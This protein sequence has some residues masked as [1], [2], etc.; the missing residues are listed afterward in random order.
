MSPIL[1][2]LTSRSDSDFER[3]NISFKENTPDGVDMNFNGF[4]TA[5]EKTKFYLV[6]SNAVAKPLKFR[7]T[8][9]GLFSLKLIFERII[10]WV[11]QKVSAFDQQ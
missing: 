7:S 9:S 11:S 6:L 10:Y 2:T 5:F 1:V 3:S 8:P 4:A